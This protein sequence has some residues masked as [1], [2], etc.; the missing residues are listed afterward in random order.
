MKGHGWVLQI[1]RQTA[2]RFEEHFLHDVAGINAGGQ[3]RIE[4]QADRAPQW[5][6]VDGQQTLD[7]LSFSSPG[8]FEQRI[9]LRL[10]GPHGV[11]RTGDSLRNRGQ[12]R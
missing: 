3:G 10:F 8:V 12:R 6:A 4:T 7:G 5:L 9:D 2:V 1:I 11:C